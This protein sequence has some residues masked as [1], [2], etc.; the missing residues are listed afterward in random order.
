MKGLLAP[1]VLWSLRQPCEV[2]GA[3]GTY[4]TSGLVTGTDSKLRENTQ[5]KVFTAASS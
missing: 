2:E 5:G 3:T 4:Y 1:C